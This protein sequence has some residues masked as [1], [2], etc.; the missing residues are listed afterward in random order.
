MRPTPRLPVRVVRHTRLPVWPAWQGVVLGAL[1]LFEPLRPL[2]DRLENS[3]GGRVCPMQFADSA[4]AD[5]F[6]LLVHHRHA[7]RALDPLC[8]LFAATILPEGFPAHPHRGF[9]T[10]TY[11]LPQRGG[12]VHRDSEGCKMKYGGGAAQWM[13]AGCGMLHEEMWDL[14]SGFVDFELYQLWVNLP[15]RYKMVPPRVQLLRG[16]S[17]DG[18]TQQVERRG[19]MAELREAEIPTRVLDGGAVLVRAIA[20]PDASPADAADGAATTFSSMRI[21][22]VQVRSGGR[23]VAPLPDGWNCIVYVREGSVEFGDTGADSA[24]ANMYETAYLG[25]AGGDCVAIRARSGSADV[26]LLAAEPIGA[27]A[28]RRMDPIRAPAY[29]R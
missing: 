9:E 6:V 5:P 16:K 14:S 2:A 12:L 17:S 15:P 22:H 27:P 28:L 21:E 1:S 29:R 23:Y 19:N 26:L 7:F 18:S 3:F 4:E 24:V 8:P 25:R 10:L 20:S 11:T 13:T